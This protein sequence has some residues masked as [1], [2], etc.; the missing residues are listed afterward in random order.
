MGVDLRGDFSISA[1]CLTAW[2]ASLAS[3]REFA[4]SCAAV[5]AAWAAVV[6]LGD[7]AN[8]WSAV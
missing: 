2:T 4:S 8:V 1:S 5:T 3:L 6:L 7:V